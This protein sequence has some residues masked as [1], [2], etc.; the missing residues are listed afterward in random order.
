MQSLQKIIVANPRGPCAGVVRAIDI[1]ELA[2][3]KFGAPVFVNHEIV[4][5]KWVV[6]DFEKRGVIFTN[7]LDDVPL[8][9]A[10]ILSAHGVSPQFRKK[11]REHASN[12][13]VIDATCPLVT[14][15]HYEALKYAKQGYQIYYIGHRGHVEAEG[16]M[17]VTPMTLVETIADVDSLSSEASDQPKVI[18]TQTTLSVDDT[19]EII[20]ALQQKFPD[21]KVPKA[22]DICYATTNRQTALKKLAEQSDKV[23]IVGS[24][25][26]S[27]S[28]RLAE[29]AQRLCDGSVLVDHYDDVPDGFLDGVKIL[30]VSS[31]ASVPD[32]LVTDLLLE[33][34]RYCG[35]CEIISLNVLEEN[36]EFPLPKE[37]R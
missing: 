3:Q 27:N 33:V 14:K 13:R 28:N 31:G 16:V 12:F 6:R 26:S 10:Y 37:L 21:I 2:L 5:N 35:E 30:G 25:N 1:V 15:V 18:L 24:K 11:V 23:I 22:Q 32:H 7:D 4:H 19:A 34:Q 8:Q 9:S 29:T 36:M 20:T 17:G